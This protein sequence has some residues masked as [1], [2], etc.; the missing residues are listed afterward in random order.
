MNIDLLFGLYFTLL[1]PAIWFLITPYVKNYIAMLVVASLSLTSFVIGAWYLSDM[2]PQTVKVMLAPTNYSNVGWYNATFMVIKNSWHFLI[3][4]IPWVIVGFVI[5][6]LVLGFVALSKKVKGFKPATDREIALLVPLVK[7]MGVET[8]KIFVGKTKGIAFSTYDSIYLSDEIANMLSDERLSALLAHELAHIVRRDQISKWS[9][10]VISAL[11][12]L[13]PSSFIRKNY[14]LTVEVETDKKAC[15][16]IEN[17]LTLAETLVLC[18]KHT[19]P[20]HGAQNITSIDQVSVRVQRILETDSPKQRRSFLKFIPSYVLPVVMTLTFAFPL[21][22]ETNPNTSLPINGMTEMQTKQLMEGEAL[23]RLERS[24]VDGKLTIVN[25][26]P[27]DDTVE[28]EDSS[29][30]RSNGRLYRIIRF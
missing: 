1:L 21:F 7:K 10:M 2:L 27:K 11:S 26:I 14:D 24:R 28:S 22:G 25:I 17:P 13:V 15:E 23:V 8:P 9:F 29:T 16:V 19:I 12:F 18:A 6:R 20:Q 30:L 3:L 4:A 5:A